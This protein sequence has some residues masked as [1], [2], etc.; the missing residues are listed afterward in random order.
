MVLNMAPPLTS[1]GYCWNGQEDIAF[2]SN[3][4]D[5]T[6]GNVLVYKRMLP[7]QARCVAHDLKDLIKYYC[8]RI[9]IKISAID[10]ILNQSE[11]QYF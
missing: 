10:E 2:F 6:L 4:G 9:Q 5:P 7:I 11:K 3:S 8:M 1:S